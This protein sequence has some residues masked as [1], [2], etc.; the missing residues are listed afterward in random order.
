MLNVAHGQSNQELVCV[1]H[2]A[3]A[4]MLQL[5][6]TVPHHSGACQLQ[7]KLPHVNEMAQS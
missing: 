6:L 4:D 7:E 1:P 3:F 2:Q 5:I